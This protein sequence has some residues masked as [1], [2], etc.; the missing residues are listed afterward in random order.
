MPDDPNENSQADPSGDHPAPS[1]SD[2]KPDVNITPP[3]YN[4]TTEG[5]D[6]DK[7]QKK[8]E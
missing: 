7:V 6:F 3:E 4:Y 8:G 5:W 1:A 2:E